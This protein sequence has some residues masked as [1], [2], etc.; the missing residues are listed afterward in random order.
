MRRQHAAWCIAST[1]R[2]AQPG[3]AAC[4][5]VRP[6]LWCWLARRPAAL[7]HLQLLALASSSLASLAMLPSPSL[8][9]HRISTSSL[10]AWRCCGCLVAAGAGGRGG[11]RGGLPAA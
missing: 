5:E 3:A 6:G 10:L 9:L 8:H 1:A 7:Q 2:S 4:L 11:C